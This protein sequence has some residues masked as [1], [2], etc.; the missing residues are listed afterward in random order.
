M[1]TGRSGQM[2][3]GRSR[4]ELTAVKPEQ[5]PAGDLPEIALVGR[6]NVGKSS[7]I[8]SLLN[9]KGL[10]RVSSEPGK[11]RG[12]NFY[13]VD[14]ILYFV[15]LPGYGYAKVS[16]EEKASWAKMIETYL[17]TRRQL[18]LVIMLVDIRHSPTEDDKL[19]YRWILDRGIAH[20]VVATKADK[21]ARGRI[22][23]RLS[24]IR[25]TLGIKA[26][27]SLTAYSSET[28]QGREQLW[29]ELEKAVLEQTVNEQI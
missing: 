28:G 23:G 25:K 5:Y 2:D 24:E 10:A 17:H 1:D 26:D 9:R 11:T 19:M 21:I 27:A 15:D 18:K 3:I 16:K 29:S 20:M 8:N 6:S 7:L 4:Y 22:Q 13:N 14:D 12:I